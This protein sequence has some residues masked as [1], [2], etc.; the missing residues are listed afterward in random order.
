MTKLTFTNNSGH[1][2]KWVIIRLR[3]K[4]DIRIKKLASGGSTTVRMSNKD[5]IHEISI[6]YNVKL[7]RDFTYDAKF[8]LEPRNIS[9]VEFFVGVNTMNFVSKM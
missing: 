6:R 7:Q 1:E 4:R 2:L 8:I 3:F 5:K 9:E